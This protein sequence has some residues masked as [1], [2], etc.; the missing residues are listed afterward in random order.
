MIRCAAMPSCPTVRRPLPAALVRAL[1]WALLGGW[2]MLSVTASTLPSESTVARYGP[3][4]QKLFHQW[5][6]LLLSLASRGDAQAL[7]SIN[8][9]FNRRIVF[10]QNRNVWNQADY[11]ATPLETFGK[12]AGDCK[13]FVINKYVSLRLLGMAPEKL[14]LVYVKARIGGAGSQVSEAHMV[15]AYYPSAAA[16]PLILDNLVDS[17]L[18]ASQRPDLTPVFSFNMD[19]IRVGNVQSDQVNQLARWKQLLDKLNAEGFSF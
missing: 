5:Q 2:L 11:W 1:V 12:G 18:P 10:A 4:A 3:Q 9:F 6:T 15:L 7:K 17:I 13:S 16:E 8:L 14:R 19:N